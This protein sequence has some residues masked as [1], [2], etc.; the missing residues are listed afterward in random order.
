[1]FWLLGP[2][3]CGILA[4]WPGI[5]HASPALEDEFLTS[6]SPEKSQPLLLISG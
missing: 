2:E 3:V 5:E 6:G 1:M 4:L